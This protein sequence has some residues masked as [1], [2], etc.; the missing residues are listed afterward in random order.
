[1][2]LLLCVLAAGCEE[3]ANSPLRFMA[4]ERGFGIGK[5]SGYARPGVYDGHLKERG[6]WIVTSDPPQM[7]VALDAACPR[8]GGKTYFDAMPQLF[9]CPK[10][11]SKWDANGLPRKGSLTQLAMVRFRIEP[12]NKA[13]AAEALRLKVTKEIRYVH[14]ENQWSDRFSYHDRQPR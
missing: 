5:A 11:A 1:M 9:R 7:T 2:L 8:D 6:I 4:P 10:C 13:S 14:E 3:A 12:V